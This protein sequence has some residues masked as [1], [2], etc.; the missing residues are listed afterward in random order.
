MPLQQSLQRKRIQRRILFYFNRNLHTILCRFIWNRD[1]ISSSS[2]NSIGSD[3]EQRYE[4][5]VSSKIREKSGLERVRGVG[6]EIR[7]F[8]PSFLSPF[9]PNFIEVSYIFTHAL[10]GYVSWLHRYWLM[11]PW[12]F[13]GKGFCCQM[14]LAGGMG[15]HWKEIW[16]FNRRRL[17]ISLF[18]LFLNLELCERMKLNL[19]KEY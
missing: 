3:I 12:I 2:W 6:N 7:F 5:R 14:E 1:E 10:S 4:V 8:S 15:E 16:D 17:S 9:P 13:P 18:F 11:S 19:V